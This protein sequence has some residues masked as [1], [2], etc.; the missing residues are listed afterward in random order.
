[1]RLTE[2]QTGYVWLDAAQLIKHAFGL[3]RILG[4][5]TVILLYLFWEPTNAS[6][7]SVFDE[8]RREIRDFSR[9]V[10]GGFPEF[11]AMSYPE[12]GERNYVAHAG[13]LLV[14]RQI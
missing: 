7:F 2:D 13:N 8:H 5:R 9:R 3:A 10:L 12:D 11:R 6:S 4:P 1:M 14:V